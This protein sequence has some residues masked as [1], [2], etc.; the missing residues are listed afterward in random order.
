[1]SEATLKTKLAPRD[2]TEG[3]LTDNHDLASV[4]YIGDGARCLQA[5]A[6]KHDHDFLSYVLRL[7]VLE[8]DIMTEK[9]DVIKRS[10]KKR[11]N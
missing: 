2:E 11:S 10:S 1:M 7:V 6:D 4:Q 8:T 9:S 3:L 5:I